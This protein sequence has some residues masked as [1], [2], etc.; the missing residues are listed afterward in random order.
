MKKRKK[1]RTKTTSG[2]ESFKKEWIK[3]SIANKAAVGPDPRK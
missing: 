2:F 1:R 3:G